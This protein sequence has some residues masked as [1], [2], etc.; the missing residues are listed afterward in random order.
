MGVN[1]IPAT[2][3]RIW[4]EQ[5]VQG[6]QCTV[7]GELNLAEGMD[8]RVATDLCATIYCNI[9]HKSYRVGNI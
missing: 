3:L 2:W 5:T 1:H 6:N 4:E 7:D 9:G 8:A